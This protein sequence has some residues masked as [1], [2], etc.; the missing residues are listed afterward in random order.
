MVWDTSRHVQLIIFSDIL[1]LGFWE[2]LDVQFCVV[3]C[4]LPNFMS[5]RGTQ[6]ASAQNW[7]LRDTEKRQTENQEVRFEITKRDTAL[8]LKRMLMVKDTEIKGKAMTF[9]T[10][11]ALVSHICSSN[12]CRPHN[13]CTRP[14]G[15]AS[16]VSQ[17]STHIGCVWVLLRQSGC[18]VG[19]S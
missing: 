12:H 4:G 18:C 11:K 8:L 15:S 14:G 9:S 7:A 1:W 6:L 13:H 16:C 19:R 5:Q 17:P 10:T 3:L 2:G